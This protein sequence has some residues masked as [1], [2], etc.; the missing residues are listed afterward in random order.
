MFLAILALL[1]TP[2]SYWKG[3]SREFLLLQFPTLLAGM[4]IAYMMSRSWKTIRGTLLVLVL[5]GLILA[6]SA[7]SGY[8]GGRAQANTMYDPN[9]LAYV[10]V[11]VLPLVIGFF[12]SARTTAR[13]LIYVGMGS[14][15][16]GAM[17]LT[18]SRG[19]F[20]GL[21]VVILLACIMRIRVTEGNRRNR[22]FL[23]LLGVCVL[24]AILWTQLPQD[25]R[26]R[27][28][29]V[30][31][32][33]NDYNLDPNNDKS[34]GQIWSRG[35]QAALNRP[36]GYGPGAFPMVDYRYGG[37]MMAAHNSYLEAAVELGI[38]GFVFFVR[39]YVLSWRGLGRAR[40]RLGERKNVSDEQKER[41]VF[42]RVLQLSLVGNAVAGFFLSMT[43]ATILWVTFGI[44][45]A[46]M[47]LADREAEES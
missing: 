38:L 9:D 8:G 24:G 1:L 40:M 44:C 36:Y 12:I 37:R 2:I 22:K 17:L 18:Q 10:L 47:A 14:V 23:W 46:V 20:L 4:T 11:T 31:N 19:G 5:S 32:L 30:L 35:F 39:M 41:M 34:R 25:A 45:M 13:R 3:A 21:V 33:S 7:V 26:D 6:R 16:L 43:Y 15:M 28:A 42:A 29:T 27:F